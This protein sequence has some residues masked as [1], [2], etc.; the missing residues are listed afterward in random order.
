MKK[1]TIKAPAKVNLTLE[2]LNK[3]EDGFHNIQSIMHTINLFDI[4]T[5]EV[6]KSPFSFSIRLELCNFAPKRRSPR[7]THFN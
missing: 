5:F 7:P 2:V 6:E 3:R 1:L 4:L